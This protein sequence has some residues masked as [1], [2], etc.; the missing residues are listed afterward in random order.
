VFHNLTYF[1]AVDT[2]EDYLILTDAG[3][4][5]KLTDKM[6]AQFKVELRYDSNPAAGSSRSDL[7]Y[8][9]GVGWNF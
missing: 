6:F 9:L 8:I 5:A 2:F 3:I 1:Q 4:Q 7:R